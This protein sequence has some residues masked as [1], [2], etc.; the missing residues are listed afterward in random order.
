M[1]RAGG[2]KA[3][4][5]KRES[6]RQRFTALALLC[7]WEI[8]PEGKGHEDDYCFKNKSLSGKEGSEKNLIIYTYMYIHMCTHI[9]LY[10]YIYAHT[11]TYVCYIKR[12]ICLRERNGEKYRSQRETMNPLLSPD[13]ERFYLA[14][15]SKQ[16]TEGKSN[17]KEFIPAKPV[18]FFLFF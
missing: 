2:E 6:Q 9:Y 7:L 18:L 13:F 11:H 15:W 16:V 12:Y 17:Q 8:S 1:K 5:S 14:C 4:T 10:T 3:P